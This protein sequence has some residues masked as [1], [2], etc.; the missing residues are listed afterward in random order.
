[1]KATRFNVNLVLRSMAVATPLMFA[2]SMGAQAT[3]TDFESRP[4]SN[5]VQPAPGPSHD[6]AAEDLNG[7]QPRRPE[8]A[9]VPEQARDTRTAAVSTDAWSAEVQY[10][11]D[12]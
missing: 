8:N 9:A 12:E 3:P 10:L 11:G 7:L 1:M 5:L 6:R 2:V 4:S